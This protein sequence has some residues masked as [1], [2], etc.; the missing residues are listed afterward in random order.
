MSMGLQAAQECEKEIHFQLLRTQ[1]FL[2]LHTISLFSG[3]RCWKIDD[4]EREEGKC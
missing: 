2:C 1:H 3:V 4:R